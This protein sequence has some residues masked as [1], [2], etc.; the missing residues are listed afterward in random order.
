MTDLRQ[1]EVSVG[2]R[3]LVERGWVECEPIPR[4]GKGRP[5][6]RY[7]L[8]AD[9]ERL[10]IHYE[11]LAQKAQG[12]LDRAMQVMQGTWGERRSRSR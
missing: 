7:R 12:A 2:M 10:H 6:N 11:A 8:I 1:P 9:P 5:M 3:D 4:E